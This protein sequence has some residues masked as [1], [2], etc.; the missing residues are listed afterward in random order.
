MFSLFPTGHPIGDRRKRP[1]AVGALIGALAVTA[2]GGALT[3]GSAALPAAAHAAST[4]PLA[5][6]VTVTVGGTPGYTTS[7]DVLRGG[8]SVLDRIGDHK[9]ASVTGQATVAGGA[10]VT[11]NIAHAGSSYA[12][13]FGLADATAGVRIDATVKGGLT[14]PSD[15]TVTW[16]GSAT[17]RRGAATSTQP[18]TFT[19]VD[20]VLDPGDHVVTMVHAGQTRYAAVHVPTGKG[21]VRGLPALVHFPGLGENAYFAEQFSELFPAADQN[22]YLMVVPE[23]YGTGWQGVPG[24]TALPNVD[25][26]GY[27]QALMD[28]V[29][30]R[31]GADPKRLYSSG[32]SNGSWFSQLTACRLNT[33]YAAF[34][35]VSGPLADQKNCNPGRHVPVLMFHG[36]TDPLVPYSG[37]A[38]ALAFWVKNNGCA[39]TT[40]DTNLPDVDPND[41]TTIV[42]HVYQNCPPDGPVIF[43]QI[44]GGGHNWP[45]G[46]PFLPGNVLG[47]TTNDINGNQVI[48][49]FVS[50]FRLP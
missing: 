15:D 2:P 43:Y 46:K 13:T 19:V 30:S 37:A 29:K 11:V 8:V 1:G 4:A 7:G 28:V 18:V 14:R 32:M 3:L 36:T 50:R 16:S 26:L 25:D 27:V 6:R 21:G 33:L 35:A 10:A 44:I 38:P 49:D 12:G 42:R 5:D 17:V 48:W 9:T 31:F 47:G 39:S 45:G 41:G 22:G 20:R 34:V 23:H 24:G 40:T